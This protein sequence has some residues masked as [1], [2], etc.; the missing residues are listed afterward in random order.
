[1]GNERLMDALPSDIREKLR[2]EF[3][4]ESKQVAKE[5]EKTVSPKLVK[6]LDK[7]KAIWDQQAIIAKSK[8][9]KNGNVK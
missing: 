2:I 7:Q 3:E 1:M 4:E 6:Y 5:K 8:N 9:Q